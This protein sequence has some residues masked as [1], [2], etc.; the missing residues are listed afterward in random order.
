MAGGW[1]LL[2]PI[3]HAHRA[4][5]PNRLK[6][7]SKSIALLGPS[8]T[9]LASLGE[10]LFSASGGIVTEEASLAFQTARELDP[11]DPRPQFFLAVGYGAVGQD[12]DEARAAFSGDDG[13]GA[14]GRALDRRC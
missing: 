4:V 6:R 2:G 7:S 8:P 11:T 10:A 1:A 14:A 5:S 12:A 13:N 9:R 3:Y